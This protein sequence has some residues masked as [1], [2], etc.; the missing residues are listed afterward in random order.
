MTSGAAEPSM[1]QKRGTRRSLESAS[2]FAL[3][4]KKESSS[5]FDLAWLEATKRVSIKAIEPKFERAFF[6]V[7]APFMMASPLL[8]RV[9]VMIK[10]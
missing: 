7:V 1:S 10:A 8:T 4:W 9:P 2:G 6:A 5:G 3:S